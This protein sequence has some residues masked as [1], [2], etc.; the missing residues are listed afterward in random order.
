MALH[1][2]LLA[3]PPVALTDRLSRAGRVKGNSI[4]FASLAE[5]SGERTLAGPVD[6]GGRRGFSGPILAPS[7]I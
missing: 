7:V 2:A 5:R 4:V 3:D 1:A 6:Y